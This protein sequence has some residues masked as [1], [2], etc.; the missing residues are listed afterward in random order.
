[1][2]LR[3]GTLYGGGIPPFIWYIY[4]VGK[5]LYKTA[6]KIGLPKIGA[7]AVANIPGSLTH[8]SG[9]LSRGD[10]DDATIW[11]SVSE[12]LCTGFFYG[13]HKLY[14]SSRNKRSDYKEGNLARET[15]DDLVRYETANLK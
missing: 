15:I 14:E 13:V 12:L 4:Y 5:P 1:M 9:M 11:F 8:V 6:R 2:K 3:Q 10:F 7:L